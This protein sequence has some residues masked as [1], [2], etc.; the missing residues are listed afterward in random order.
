MLL[1][2]P[3]TSWH[4]P[5]AGSGCS[6]PPTVV[7]D[8][9]TVTYTYDANGNMLTASGPTGTITTAYDRLDRPTSVVPDDGSTTTTTTYGLT[10][11]SITTVCAAITYTRNR[12]GLVRT[13]SSDIR[14]TGITD[15]ANGTAA[16]AYDQMGRL[17]GYDSPVASS[18]DL[19][20]AW[21]TVLDR[22]GVTTDPSGTPS[23]VTTTFDAADRPTSD[24]AGGSY[25]HDAQG[26][27]TARPGH[28]ME[29]DSLGE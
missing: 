29:W 16:F 22:T 25:A 12:A 6:T 19:D 18:G 7:A 13:E 8:S 1:P 3:S 4:V 20:Y 9:V 5:D 26:R 27:M 15:P 21:D 10:S 23:T 2:W 24:T 28:T 11:G 14:A 17:V